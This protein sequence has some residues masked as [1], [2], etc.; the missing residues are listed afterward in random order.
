MLL[1]IAVQIDSACMQYNS[2]KDVTRTSEKQNS[3]EEMYFQR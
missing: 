3:S 2:D 1:R